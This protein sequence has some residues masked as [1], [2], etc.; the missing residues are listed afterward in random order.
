MKLFTKF[1]LAIVGVTMF[2]VAI[3]LA[4]QTYIIRITQNEAD[5]NTITNQASAVETLIESDVPPV[6]IYANLRLFSITEEAAALIFYEYAPNTPTEFYV[7]EKFKNE[8]QEHEELYM[9]YVD[10]ESYMMEFV[11]SEDNLTNK[12]LYGRPMPDGS[13][14]LLSTNTVTLQSVLFENLSQMGTV[15]LI[16]VA[17][18]T[19]L[20]YVL[21]KNI[22]NPLSDIVEASSKIA[23]GDFDIDISVRGH[24]ELTDVASSINSMSKELKKASQF[25]DDIISNVSHNLKTPIAA[26]LTYC[27]L[28]QSCEMDEAKKNE[29]IS[30]INSRAINLEEMVKSLILLS[31]IQTGSEPINYTKLNLYELIL[32]CL[33][34]FNIM[35]EKKQISVDFSFD[36]KEVSVISDHEKLHTILT[37]LISNAVNYTDVGG[38]VNV[39][40]RELDTE[41]VVGV[42]D[43]GEGISEEELPHIWERFYKATDSTLNKDKGTGLGLDI[44]RR[45]FGL[46]KYKYELKSEKGVGTEIQFTI[47]KI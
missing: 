18:S 42:A 12:I 24:D 32:N 21:S 9:Q 46:M 38:N 33:K 26:I 6:D 31:K 22:T 15:V 45:L 27:E 23:S 5:S 8:L 2:V 11:P 10:S 20:S 43:S 39:Y 35:F 17:L 7:N 44:V 30:I 28:L 40:L 4:F 29:C 47:K 14:L 1:G 19:A 36:S 41:V 16:S 13:Y 3:A 25:K 37:N 34:E